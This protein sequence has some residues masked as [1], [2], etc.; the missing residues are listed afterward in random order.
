MIDDNVSLLTY[1]DLP[2]EKKNEI[3]KNLKKH[4]NLPLGF[5]SETYRIKIN[6]EI[7]T[8][9]FHS[10]MKNGQPMFNLVFSGKKQPHKPFNKEN[11]IFFYDNELQR[12]LNLNRETF[13]EILDKEANFN[14]SSEEI[15]LLSEGK[16]ITI[17][18]TNIKKEYPSNIRKNTKTTISVDF[19]FFLGKINL[20]MKINNLQK[21]NLSINANR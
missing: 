9:R 20:L 8:Y 17:D 7:K 4:Q 18:I 3:L 5:Y 1:A 11:T 15:D 21:N 19:N 16:E 10:A 14:L 6:E 2:L 12:S 13:E